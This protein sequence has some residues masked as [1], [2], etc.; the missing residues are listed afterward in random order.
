MMKKKK[1]G[2]KRL[3]FS[4]LG[5]G[6]LALAFVF[7]ASGIAMAYGNS[8]VNNFYGNANINQSSENSEVGSFGSVEAADR[9]GFSGFTNV[10][11]T[12]ELRFGDDTYGFTTDGFSEG[13]KVL[14]LTNTSTVT[15]LNNTGETL[16]V[17]DGYVRIQT[18]T[19]TNGI[20]YLVGTSSVAVVAHDDTTF[21]GGGSSISKTGVLA[22]TTLADTY[23][24]VD[25]A[26]TDT[27]YIGNDVVPVLD[28]EYIICSA[29]S[30]T[31][32]VGASSQAAQCV[33]R[34]YTLDD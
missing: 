32:Y 12:G 9:G 2:C 28:G 3:N 14:T 22:G 15:E 30:T 8:I 17:Y 26:G 11:V 29:S 23:F 34:F 1:G 7:V 24:K 16:Y 25:F 20:Q 33:V 18:A 21:N 4:Y 6:V 19:T 10:N 5:I 13:Y 27:G 31:E